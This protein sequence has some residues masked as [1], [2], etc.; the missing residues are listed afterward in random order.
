MAELPGVDQ[1]PHAALQDAP[2]EA[3]ADGPAV[4]ESHADRASDAT[5][6]PVAEITP[7]AE[8]IEE[9][10]HSESSPEAL[11]ATDLTEASAPEAQA[12]P[13]QA[14]KPAPVSSELDPAAPKRSGWW[15]RAKASLGS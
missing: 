8:P 1:T 2:S 12:E 6:V 11:A 13:A 4:D 3:K 15:Q 7:V 9:P 10:A 5:T 14:Q